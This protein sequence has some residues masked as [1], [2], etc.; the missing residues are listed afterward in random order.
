MLIVPEP[1]QQHSMYMRLAHVGFDL[2][3]FLVLHIE[4]MRL[5]YSVNRSRSSNFYVATDD[6]NNIYIYIYNYLGDL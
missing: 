5:Y 6:T 4:K 3:L 2:M 1:S